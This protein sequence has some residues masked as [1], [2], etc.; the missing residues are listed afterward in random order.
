[1]PMT[2]EYA[3]AIKNYME[4]LGIS[5]E[6]AIQL[7][8]DDHSG[9]ESAEMK[10]MER[11]SKKNKRYEKSDT[12]KK[13]IRKEDPVKR[14]IISTLA[15]NVDRSWFEDNSRICDVKIVKPEKEF[16]F[17]IGSDCYSVTLTK[18]RAPK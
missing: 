12:P 16:T 3:T 15:Q 10:E 14:E 5:K 13:Y 17:K 9:Y 4:K 7:W 11:K 6:E 18:H 2:K 1:M 8:E